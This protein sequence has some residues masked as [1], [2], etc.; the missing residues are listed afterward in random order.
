MGHTDQKLAGDFSLKG[1]SVG[2]PGAVTEYCSSLPSET[3]CRTAR[4]VISVCVN[5]PQLQSCCSGHGGQWYV[6]VTGVSRELFDY[7]GFSRA[8]TGLWLQ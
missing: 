2:S 8:T 3:P 6:M 7:L 5:E 1:G 4:S